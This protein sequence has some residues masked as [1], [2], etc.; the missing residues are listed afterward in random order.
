M[1]TRFFELLG[2]MAISVGTEVCELLLVDL[3]PARY[4][5]F[6][7][8]ILMRSWEAC[9]F[10]LKLKFSSCDCELSSS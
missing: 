4:F 3:I 1:T 9:G 8:S 5:S 2:L 6:Y 7:T 10:E